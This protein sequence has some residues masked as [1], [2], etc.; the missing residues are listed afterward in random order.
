MKIVINVCFGGFGLSDEGILKYAEIKGIKLYPEKAKLS[1]GSDNYYTVPVCEYWELRKKDI[2]NGNYELS[3][4]AYFSHYHIDRDDP[5]L[6]ETVEQLGNK[7]NGLCASLK[8]VEI[9]DGIEWEIDE[10]DGNET[11]HEK[12]K[13]WS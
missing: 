7:A 10:Y 5:A 3:N 6:I 1:L 4:A 2:A 8:I 9:P 13:S 12:H 11:I